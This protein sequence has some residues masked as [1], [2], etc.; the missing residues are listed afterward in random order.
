MLIFAAS[1]VAAFL[2]TVKRLFCP[3]FRRRLL[4]NLRLAAV[5]AAALAAP[6]FFPPRL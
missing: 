3:P 1:F 5:S 6:P 2:N 4:G